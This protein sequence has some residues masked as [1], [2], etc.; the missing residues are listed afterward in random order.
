MHKGSVNQMDSDQ[1][2][3]GVPFPDHFS[4]WHSDTPGGTAED[5]QWEVQ[6]LTRL[7]YEPAVRH[8]LLR[9]LK[10]RRE[11]GGKDVVQ[12]DYLPVDVGFDTLMV[13][14]ELLITRESYVG[15]PGGLQWTGASLSAKPYLDALGLRAV[16]V[17]CADL[18]GKILRLV[19][20]EHLEIGRA[21]V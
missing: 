1:P 10:G 2:N 12:F 16:P 17:D 11:D 18:A 20:S 5:V 13:K 19:P 4:D 14:G 21:H 7:R 15:Y 9:L 6:Q 8:E 3:R